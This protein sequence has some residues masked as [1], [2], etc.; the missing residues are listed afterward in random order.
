MRPCQ[1]CVDAAF[2]VALLVPPVRLGTKGFALFHRLTLLL[3]TR[4]QGGIELSSACRLNDGGE[5]TAKKRVSVC[6]SMLAGSKTFWAFFKLLTKRVVL[7]TVKEVPK[8]GKA[9]PAKVLVS[10]G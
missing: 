6:L 7:N 2:F 5:N 10:A 4:R 3:S 1:R 9:A 8:G